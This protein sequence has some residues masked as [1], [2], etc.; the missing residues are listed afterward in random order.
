MSFEIEKNQNFWTFIDFFYYRDYDEM[1]KNNIFYIESLC[2]FFGLSNAI[3]ME[4]I[5]LR[6]VE[7]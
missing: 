6:V 1:I 2:T 5:K 7:K 4:E 3:L